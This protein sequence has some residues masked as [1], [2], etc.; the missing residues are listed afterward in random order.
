MANPVTAVALLHEAKDRGHRAA[1]HTA[2]AG[3][4]GRI[5]FRIAS[6]AGFPVIHIVRR[7]E[8]VRLLRELGDEIVLNATS[9]DF[10]EQLKEVS[11]RLGAT[12]AFDPIGGES[13]G[14]L[15]D[16]LP[17]GSQIV[18]Y[19]AL[20]LEDARIDPKRLIF[21]GKQIEGFWFP[22]WT[23]KKGTWHMISCVRKAIKGAGKD[24][25][26]EVAERV[27]LDH[28]RQAIL[29]YEDDMTRGKV[30]LIPSSSQP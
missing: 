19:G 29:R 16:A 5:L 21:E 6:K 26:T 20:S 15:V 18:V 2:A 13:T 10:L 14:Q 22:E 9:P 30:L 28:V 3:A 4:L 24:W 1:V 12:I 17:K 11:Q 8:Q 27:P 7:E 23:K 25:T